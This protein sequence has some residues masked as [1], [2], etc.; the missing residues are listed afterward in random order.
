MSAAY[1]RLKKYR[2]KQ[3]AEVEAEVSTSRNE[4][5]NIEQ[6]EIENLN[7]SLEMPME[8]S[9]GSV[10][11]NL[12]SSSQHTNTRNH[13]SSYEYNITSDTSS[14]YYESPLSSPLSQHSS[15]MDSSDNL[16]NFDSNINAIVPSLREKLR[17]FAVQ[18]RSNMTV[19]MI[20][21]L[22]GI[23]RSENHSD[24]P[25][26]AVGLL[27]T[28]S[29][30]NIVIMK[31][32]KNTNGSYVY[33]GIEEGLKSIM[34]DDYTDNSIRILFN[35]D[36]LPLY[37]SSSHQF[38][39]ILGLILHN[40]YESNPF[41]VA[42]FSGDSKPQNVNNFLEDFVQETITLIHNGFII[43]Q[44]HFKIEIVGLSCDTPARSFIKK[45]KGHGGFYA[46]ERCETR[47]KTINNKRV[48]PSINSKL[49]TKKSF[50]RQHQPEHHLDGRT[51]LLD[52]PKFDP[53]RCVFLDSMHLLYLGTMKW[54]LQQLIGT[55]SR[56]NR[57]C[58]LSR[59]KIQ[60]LNSTLKTFVNFVP[61]EFQRKKLD[62]DTFNYWK[63]TQFRFF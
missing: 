15:H 45:C 5:P 18:F 10:S 48:Y 57:K 44:R 51:R 32:S 56:V 38:W 22:L 49:R 25:K 62:L 12:L 7:L 36:G 29:N 3:S 28:K 17:N 63:A 2:Q 30:D 52:I 35:I 54:I 41:I 4:V 40:D 46:C 50:R 6:N 23:L 42:V 27:Q 55:N 53:V 59:C 47:G 19:E 24:L 8:V 37:N 13:D 43:G 14:L 58:K 39:P 33:F 34:T 21:N 61:K 11:N 1:Y 60:E 26:S 20:E 16:G 9:V 31:S